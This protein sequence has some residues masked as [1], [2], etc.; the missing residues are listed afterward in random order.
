MHAS[1]IGDS[2]FIKLFRLDDIQGKV[3]KGSMFKGGMGS[4]KKSYGAV[5]GGGEGFA[6][7]DVRRQNH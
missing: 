2:D 4:T 6:S 7:R 1:E 5:A 3:V